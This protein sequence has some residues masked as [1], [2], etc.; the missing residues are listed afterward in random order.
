QDSC[1]KASNFLDYL[2][3][4]KRLELKAYYELNSDLL[5]YKID[6]F[7]V[8]LSRTSAKQISPAIKQQLSDF[9]N[10]LA[11]LASSIP[12]DEKRSDILSRRIREKKQAAEWRWLL[13]KAEV[14]KYPFPPNNSKATPSQKPDHH[15]L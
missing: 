5:P 1:N 8:Y 14:L 7:K 6:A 3:T 13:E 11:Q 10:F 4:G 15:N 2:L 12:G 9:I